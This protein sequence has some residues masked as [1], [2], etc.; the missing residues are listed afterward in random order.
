M[1]VVVE[2]WSVAVPKPVGVRSGGPLQDIHSSKIRHIIP[3]AEACR[4]SSRTALASGG[5]SGGCRGPSR[6]WLS[7]RNSHNAK[8][9]RGSGRYSGN[10]VSTAAPLL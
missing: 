9:M 2:V 8:V 7:K 10:S 3:S 4:L 6:Y 5:P 1:T